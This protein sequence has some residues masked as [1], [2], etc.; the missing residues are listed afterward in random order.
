MGAALSAVSA[1]CGRCPW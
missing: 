1:G